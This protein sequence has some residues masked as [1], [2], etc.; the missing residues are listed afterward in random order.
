M[1]TLFRTCPLLIIAVLVAAHIIGC[2]DVTT[3]LEPE[4]SE[5]IDRTVVPD[6]DKASI[7]TDGKPITVTDETFDTVVLEAELPIVLEFWAV[8]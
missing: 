6:E 4:D 7:P 3:E 8:W 1:K 2:G 5:A